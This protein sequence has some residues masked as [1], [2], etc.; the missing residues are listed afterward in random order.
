MNIPLF[1]TAPGFDRPLDV[2]KHC[3]GRIRKQVRTMQNLLTHLPRAGADAEARQAAENVLRYFSR[4]AHQHHADEEEN[5]LP[6]LETTATGEDAAVLRELLPQIMAEHVRMGAAWSILERQLVA[7]AKGE[8]TT[9][10]APDVQA[11]AD[12]YASHMEKEE[13]VIAPMA[14]RLFN[15]K[16]I[17]TLG[18]AMCARRGVLQQ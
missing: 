13:S 7:I 2:L 5:L 18:N 14:K 3:H 4:A 10:N 12:L 15:A 16:Q 1:D 9:L 6:M 8:S 17:E 11:F